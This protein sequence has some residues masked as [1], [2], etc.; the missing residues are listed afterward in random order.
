MLPNEILRQ[1]RNVLK[2]LWIALELIRAE[3]DLQEQIPIIG[4]LRFSE[5]DLVDQ[6]RPCSPLP[7]GERSIDFGTDK[8]DLG[9]YVSAFETLR[10]KKQG[11]PVKKHDNIPL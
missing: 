5:T 10:H 4:N 2:V 8:G 7:L 6:S 3:P 11:M 1:I 9:S